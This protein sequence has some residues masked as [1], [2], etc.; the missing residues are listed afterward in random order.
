MW[1]RPYASDSDTVEID[2]VGSYDRP[3]VAAL[4]LDHAQAVGVVQ[5]DIDD[6]AITRRLENVLI[7][8]HENAGDRAPFTC[9]A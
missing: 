9:V 6:E 2:A 1:A 3:D 4:F 8:W 7:R 5:D